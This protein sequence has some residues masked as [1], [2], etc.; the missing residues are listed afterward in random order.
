MLI[1]VRRREWGDRM[2][3]GIAYNPLVPPQVASVDTFLGVVEAGVEAAGVE[4]FVVV[5]YERAC[6]SRL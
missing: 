4:G 2:G 3:D 1:G 5:G 6:V